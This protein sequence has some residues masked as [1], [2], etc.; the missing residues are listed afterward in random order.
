MFQPTMFF[1]SMVQWIGD[2]CKSGDQ[3]VWLLL[4]A[5]GKQVGDPDTQGLGQEECVLVGDATD[6]SLDFRQG[7]PGDVQARPLAFGREL[8]LGEVEPIPQLGHLF[9][10]DVRGQVLLHFWN[11]TLEH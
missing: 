7:S 2:L 6:S 11:L 1:L 9:T 8:V 5:P 10:Y 4:L 3:N